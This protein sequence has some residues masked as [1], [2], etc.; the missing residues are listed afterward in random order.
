MADPLV[1]S[2]VSGSKISYEPPLAAKRLAIPASTACGVA[3]NSMEGWSLIGARHANYRTT[4][5]F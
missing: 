5:D 2:F 1:A 3:H 4:V